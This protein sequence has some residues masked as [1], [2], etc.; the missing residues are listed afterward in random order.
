VLLHDEIARFDARARTYTPQHLFIRLANQATMFG[1][2]ELKGPV[3]HRFRGGTAIAASLARGLLTEISHTVAR[4]A[5]RY[6]VAACERRSSA[7][8]QASLPEAGNGGWLPSRR[9]G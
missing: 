6:D 4:L 7:Q 9:A 1:N 8:N 2:D 5:G 3:R